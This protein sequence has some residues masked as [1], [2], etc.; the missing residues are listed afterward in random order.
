MVGNHKLRV[1]LLIDYI[2]SDYS[3]YMLRGMQK[4]C[5][6]FDEATEKGLHF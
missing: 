1:G 2:Y 4:A 6:D 5:L 3:Q